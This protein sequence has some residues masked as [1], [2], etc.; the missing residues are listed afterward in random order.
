MTTP[1]EMTAVRSYQCT[2]CRQWLMVRAELAKGYERCP[3][4]NS[5][6][7][8]KYEETV[9]TLDLPAE[10]QRPGLVRRA[11]TK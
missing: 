5:R 7:A 1:R 8:F 3:F 6:M 4:C 2:N 10:L 11:P 9:P